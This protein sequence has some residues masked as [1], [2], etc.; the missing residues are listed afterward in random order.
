MVLE[1]VV[2][3]ACVS[4]IWEYVCKHGIYV[5]FHPVYRVVPL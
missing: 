2:L 3:D 1:S 4:S 5:A